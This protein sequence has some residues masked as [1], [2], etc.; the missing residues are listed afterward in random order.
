MGTAF[1]RRCI[2]SRGVAPRSHT[3][4]MLRS[5]RLAGRAPR[6]PRCSPP[7]MRWV[8]VSRVRNPLAFGRRC[9]PAGCVAHRSNIPD[10]LALRALPAGRIT[11]LGARRDFH[12]GLLAHVVG[13]VSGVFSQRW[14]EARDAAAHDPRACESPSRPAARIETLPAS[15]R[16]SASCDRRPDTSGPEA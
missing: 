12:H 13:I 6:R 11:G 5:S 1:G 15:M 7:F 16:S 10:I 4:G 8:L 14:D 2:P 9:I 3:P